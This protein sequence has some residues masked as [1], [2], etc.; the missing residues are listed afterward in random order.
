LGLHD[1]EKFQE[2][3]WHET[4]FFRTFRHMFQWPPVPIEPPTPVQVHV[5]NTQQKWNNRALLGYTGKTA[6]YRMDGIAVYTDFD[7]DNITVQGDYFNL[8]MMLHSG[9]I[10]PEARC[11][12]QRNKTLGYEITWELA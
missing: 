7:A 1:G 8:W 3:S 4:I 11:G 6:T 9:A 5:H 12:F 2:P 10:S